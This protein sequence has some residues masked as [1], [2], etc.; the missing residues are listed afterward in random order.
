MV[1]RNH[2]EYRA[3]SNGKYFG[4]RSAFKG[5]LNAVSGS[6][7]TPVI[8]NIGTCYMAFGEPE[9]AVKSYQ[10]AV[11]ADPCYERGWTDLK[12]HFRV[13]EECQIMETRH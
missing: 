9:L 1:T 8:N 3:W 12:M 7:R 2:P 13:M 6:D 11:S 5:E 10:N 4:A